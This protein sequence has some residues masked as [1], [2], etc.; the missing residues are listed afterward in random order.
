MRSANGPTRSH[1]LSPK[2]HL[3]VSCSRPRHRSSGDFPA[4]THLGV[5]NHPRGSFRFRWQLHHA[6]VLEV[7]LER[8]D[9][10]SHQAYG[11]LRLSIPSMITWRGG[12]Q[13][14]DRYCLASLAAAATR[15]T[16]G[17]PS[18]RV[19][20]CGSRC[21]QFLNSWRVSC[22]I[23]LDWKC[24]NHSRSAVLRNQYRR[25]IFRQVIT[26]D[27]H[28]RPFILIIDPSLPR[29]VGSSLEM[30]CEIPRDDPVLLS[31]A[32]QASARHVH[33][34]HPLDHVPRSPCLMVP[35]ARPPQA[36]RG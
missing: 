35:P 7:A 21:I 18:L 27:A 19:V 4:E 30:G 24:G 23:S 17:S 14:G 11:R 22:S 33:D 3:P 20:A 29:N 8:S 28:D 25:C 16:A 6:I 34:L 15:T 31:T 13:I 36:L 1:T 2:T 12:L 26:V 9:H 32:C 5:K 10:S